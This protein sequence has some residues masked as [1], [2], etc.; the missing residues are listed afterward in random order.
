MSNGQPIDL[1]RRGQ[2]DPDVDEGACRRS[3]CT[4]QPTRPRRSC[5]ATS[6]SCRPAA[7]VG[8]AMVRLALIG[9]G[10][11][12]IRRRLDGGDARQSA[13]QR[14]P[15][16]QRSSRRCRRVKRH[17]ALVGFMAA[18]KSHDRTALGARTRAVRSTTPTSLSSSITGRS[19]R[20]SSTRV[21]AAF[22][23]Y[24]NA[25]VARVLDGGEPRRH[26]ARRRRADAL[27]D[28]RA[29][30]DER[31]YARLHQDF[32]RSGARAHARSRVPCVRCSARRR[33]SPRSASSTPSACRCTREAE[34][35]DRRRCAAPRAQAV[36][37]MIASAAREEDRDLGSCR[38]RG[39][40][41]GLGYPIVIGGSG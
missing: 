27:G 2:A 12:E 26:R 29:L 14:A 28:N 6:A 13:P 33:R 4:R 1:A 30:V 9:A 15:R 3:T 25:A 5:A 37:A 23:H 36:D 39:G 8:E 38:W 11:R 41:R 40:Q 32:A 7:I 31:A 24:E 19:R 21:S 22:R 10:P 35:V 34:I 20:S 16:P 18:G 17:V